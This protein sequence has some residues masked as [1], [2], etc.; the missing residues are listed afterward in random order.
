MSLY[1][2]LLIKSEGDS[3]Q[4]KEKIEKL[5]KETKSIVNITLLN[6]DPKLDKMIAD[7]SGAGTYVRTSG[8]NALMVEVKVDNIGEMDRIK[9]KLKNIS[10]NI[11][12]FERY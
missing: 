1:A 3:S 6:A 5:K 10:S 8:T 7:V 11:Q 12:V 4:V 9:E 2:T